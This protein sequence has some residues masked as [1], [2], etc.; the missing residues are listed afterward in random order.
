[1]CQVWDLTA[2]AALHLQQLQS[3]VGGERAGQPQ[4]AL[5]Q[6]R[7]AGT[8]QRGAECVQLPTHLRRMYSDCRGPPLWRNESL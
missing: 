7:L 1:M 3:G 4:H 6:R 5:Q 8:Q 2:A